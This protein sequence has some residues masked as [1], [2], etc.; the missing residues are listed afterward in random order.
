MMRTVAAASALLLGLSST[1]EAG[2]GRIRFSK[3]YASAM[4]RAK[5]ERKPAAIYFTADW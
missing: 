4:A 1:A 2:V 3:D 5:K